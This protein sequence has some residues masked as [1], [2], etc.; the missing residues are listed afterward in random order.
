MTTPEFNPPHDPG[1]RNIPRSLNHIINNLNYRVMI[2]VVD[3]AMRKAKDGREFYVLILQG[4][5]S[6]VQSQK[7]GNY[8]VTLKRC[9][10]PS[11]FDETRAKSMIGEKVPGSVQKKSCDLYTFVAKETG[12][13]NPVVGSFALLFEDEARI[14]QN[15]PRV[16]SLTW[17]QLWVNRSGLFSIARSASSLVKRR[18]GG[19]I[20]RKVISSA[21]SPRTSGS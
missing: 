19:G 15:H 6:L 17:S 11:T 5:L 8:Y 20:R 2:T 18:R 13:G 21:S 14:E 12:Q 10:I 9:S 3:T 4:G 16:S 1:N 7:S